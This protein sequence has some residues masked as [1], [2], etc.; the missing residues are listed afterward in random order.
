MA[1]SNIGP[2]PTATPAASPAAAPAAQSVNNV[3]ARRSNSQDVATVVNLS[4]QGQ[5]L[6]QSAQSSTPAQINQSQLNPSTAGQNRVNL[7]QAN[8]NLPAQNT[9]TPANTASGPNTVPPS[10]TASAAPGISLIQGERKGG[11]INTYA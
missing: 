8:Q 10:G 9:N 5:R 6:S 11:Q 7:N 3:S 4:T 2:Q 1:I